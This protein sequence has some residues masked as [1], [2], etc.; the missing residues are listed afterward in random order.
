ML[1]NMGGVIKA[2]PLPEGLYAFT[3]D[4]VEVRETKGK[5]GNFNLQVT[6]RVTESPEEDM[7]AGRKYTHFQS[8]HENSLP[9]V[10]A[11]LE[12]FT[13]EEWSADGMDLDPSA[14]VGLQAKDLMYLNKNKNN[15]IREWYPID[16]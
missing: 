8:L 16:D 14:L 2:G 11:F 4:D 13:N 6:L 5:A 12:A 1:L 9:F 7:Y 15:K 3:V 10:K